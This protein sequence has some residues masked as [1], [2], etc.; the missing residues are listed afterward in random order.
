MHPLSPDSME[1]LIKNCSKKCRDNGIDM[2]E[3][4]HCHM[5]RKT[6]AM[7]LYQAGVSL[8]HIQQLLGHKHISTTSGFY[9]FASLETLS[10]AMKKA[11]SESETS[12]KCWMDK[13]MLEK[14]YSL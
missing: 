6:R 12:E 14:L 7:D 9:A 8:E 5:I 13:A 4:C 3:A 1:K 11:G 2:P 10:K